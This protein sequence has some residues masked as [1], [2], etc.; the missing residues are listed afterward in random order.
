M[1]PDAGRSVVIHQWSILSKP[2]S[3]R[4]EAVGS[5]KTRSA[6]SRSRLGRHDKHHAVGPRSRSL[7]VAARIRCKHRSDKTQTSRRTTVAYHGSCKASPWHKVATLGEVDSEQRATRLERGGITVLGRHEPR[8]RFSCTAT[9]VRYDVDPIRRGYQPAETTPKGIRTPVAGVKSRCPRPLDD[10]GL[11]GPRHEDRIRA[12]SLVDP[13]S[14]RYCSNSRFRANSGLVVS[15]FATHNRPIGL[16]IVRQMEGDFPS[17]S[18]PGEW[19]VV[20]RRPQQVH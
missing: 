4:Q 6:P 9:D 5:Q 12:R 14:T 17:R 3:D 11:P 16:E 13:T 20:S 15:E 18:L 2:S 8:G 7:T 1:T 19:I 10:G